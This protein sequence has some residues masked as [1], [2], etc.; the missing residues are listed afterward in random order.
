[1]IRAGNSDNEETAMEHYHAR[2][3]LVLFARTEIPN[4]PLLSVWLGISWCDYRQKVDSCYREDQDSGHGFRPEQPFLLFGKDIVPHTPG[5]FFEASIVMNSLKAIKGM[6]DPGG[7]FSS[8][9][10]L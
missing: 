7:R 5:L 10:N 2:L 8:L 1:M 4:P 3:D 6:S 9:E